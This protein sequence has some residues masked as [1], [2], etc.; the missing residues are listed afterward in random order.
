M[1]NLYAR[2]FAWFYDRAAQIAEEKVLAERRRTL[3]SGLKG[4]I[5]EV[6]AGTG[7]NFAFYDQEANVLAIEPSPYMLRQAEMVRK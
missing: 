3:L 4:N 1:S 6:G 5:L 2:L 7:A